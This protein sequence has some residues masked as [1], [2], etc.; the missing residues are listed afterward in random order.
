MAGTGSTP[1]N[2]LDQKGQHNKGKIVTYSNIAIGQTT[3]PIKNN[4]TSGPFTISIAGGGGG[5]GGGVIY[6]NSA[7]ATTGSSDIK[8]RAIHIQGDARFEGNI[9][10]QGRD[11]REWFEAVES[12]LALLRPNL[13]L[14]SEWEELSELRQRYVELER[15]I[16]AKQQLFDILKKN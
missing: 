7:W 5:G 1:Q 16:I 11:M 3:I 13:D 14:E 8:S 15:D 9:E 2:K 10:W 4:S 6:N 12:R